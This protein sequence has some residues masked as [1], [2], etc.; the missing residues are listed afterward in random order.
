MK[1]TLCL[2]LLALTLAGCG[3]GGSSAVPAPGTAYPASSLC[4]PN[5]EKNWVR[6]YL[7]DV[8]LWYRDIVN[9]SAANYA[10]PS[11]YF[12]ALLVKTKDR[13]SFTESQALVDAYF[14]SGEVVG[15]GASF[16][17]GADGRLRVAY[18]ERNSPAS[19]AGIDRGTQIVNINGTPEAQIGSSAF[20]AALYPSNSGNSNSFDVL[21]LGASVTRRVTLTARAVTGTPVLKSQ[22]ISLPGGKNVGYLVFND[23]T[24]IAEA[25]LIA[26]LAEFAATPVDDLVLDLRY[27]GGGYLYIASELGYMIGGAPT[28]GK[29]FEQLRFNDKHPEKTN[30]PRSSV[31]FNDADSHYQPLPTLGLARVF[32]LTGPATCSASESVINALRPFISVIAIGAATCGKPYGFIQTNNCGRSYFA[33]E[34]DGVN[35]A[36]QGGYV[37]GLAP[38]CAVPDDLEHPFGDTK[39]RLLQTALSYQQTGS[40]P[41]SA[42]TQAATGRVAAQV[43]HEIH[44]AP[45]RA[46]RLLKTP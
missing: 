46:S 24:A 34:F 39:E 44:R 28:R 18:S 13:F 41:A 19:L 11:A 22:I 38:A 30:D 35:A 14:Q 2:S 25:P 40:C 36:G 42:M 31:L 23:H 4:T 29:V 20:L 8:Y 17:R 10:T 21:D 9:V 3:G 12:N 45:W 7:D 1:K 16:V 15:Y 37:N 5:D 32:V 26:A 6:A 43:T 27:N 33:I